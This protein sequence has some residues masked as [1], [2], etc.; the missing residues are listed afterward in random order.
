MTGAGCLVLLLVLCLAAGPEA[1]CRR[2]ASRLGSGNPNVQARRRGAGVPST[3]VE[4]EGM[5]RGVPDAGC[6][7][8][9]RNASMPLSS[10]CHRREVRDPGRRRR[11]G[12]LSHPLDPLDRALLQEVLLSLWR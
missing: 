11:C 9:L 5:R 10:W 12:S 3:W 8:W 7:E 4:G 2:A 6:G 1:M